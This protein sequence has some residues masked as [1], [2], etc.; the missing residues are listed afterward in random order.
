MER[1]RLTCLPITVAVLPFPEFRSS[2]TLLLLLESSHKR[3]ASA[4]HK[5]FRFDRP[6]SSDWQTSPKFRVIRSSNAF[7]T[8]IDLQ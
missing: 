6:L 1:G 8:P 3:K 2:K 4:V 7:H 5:A